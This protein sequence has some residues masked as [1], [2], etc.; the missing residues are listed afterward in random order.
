M[1]RQYKI[2]ATPHHKEVPYND[3]ARSADMRDFDRAFSLDDATSL[4]VN[5]VIE[6]LRKKGH[7]LRD[8]WTISL[9][10]K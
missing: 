2:T 3:M 8:D 4:V 5:G 10:F 6:E 9:R 7:D 1:E